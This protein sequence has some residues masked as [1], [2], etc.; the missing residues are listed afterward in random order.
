MK[1]RKLL[2]IALTILS[3]CSFTTNAH[4][5]IGRA[6]VSQINT[7]IFGVYLTSDPTCQTGLTAVVDLTATSKPFNMA[8]SPRLGAGEVPSGGINCV[9]MVMKN[10]VQIGI[11][12]GSYPGTSNALP[13]SVCNAG[14]TPSPA[15]ICH[16][17]PTVTWP[18]KITADAAA[19]GL[20]LASACPGAGSTTDVIP[21]YLSTF[22]ACT[23]I[24]SVDAGTPGCTAP[25]AFNHPTASADVSSGIK[26]NYPGAAGDF[27]F[28]I[29]PDQSAG[30]NGE[31][32]PKV[33]DRQASSLGSRSLGL[34]PVC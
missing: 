3:V 23:G 28:V 15:V 5:L 25:N 30:N 11:N 19:I 33:V 1:N 8:N 12:A 14:K 6:A 10:D 21:L 32:L 24:T 16:G 26:I 20:T 31:K 13:D 4:A 17:G 2:T 22:S 9:I 7:Q 29:D 18:A 27:T 34:V